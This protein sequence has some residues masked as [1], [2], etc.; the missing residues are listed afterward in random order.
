MP[1][2]PQAAPAPS[3]RTWRRWPGATRARA[4]RERVS[5]TGATRKDAQCT[6]RIDEPIGDCGTHTHR[7]VRK[8][9]MLGDGAGDAPCARLRPVRLASAVFSTSLGYCDYQRISLSMHDGAD[10]TG[11]HGRTGC[12]KWSKSQSRS[13]LV[14]AL[15]SGVSSSSSSAARAAATRSL[16]DAVPAAALRCGCEG[17]AARVSC[18]HTH[19]TPYLGATAKL[20]TR[21]RRPGS[22]P[23]SS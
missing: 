13:V 22:A 6:H 16:Y 7:C 2:L 20:R 15:P 1:Q 21:V 11:Q 4:A 14:A 17:A 8:R 12:R 3:R 19:V 10:A 5:G 23:P 9:A 18:Q